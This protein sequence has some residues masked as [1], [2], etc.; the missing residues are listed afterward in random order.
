MLK[1]GSLGHCDRT[2]TK[3]AGGLTGSEFWRLF[4]REIGSMPRTFRIILLSLIATGLT[5]I[6]TVWAQAPTPPP[7]GP[8]GGAPAAGRGPAIPGFNDVLATVTVG[9]QTEKVT[10]GELIEILSRYAIPDDDRETLYRQGIDNKVNTKLLLMYL[11]RQKVAVAPE[12]VDEEMGKL[13]Q[14]LKSEGQSLATVLLQTNTSM[15][16]VRKQIEERARWQ[17]FLR[18]KATDAE[19]R[20]YV[21]NHRDL[22][23]GTQ[24]RASHILLKLEPNAS[25]ADK[26][27]VKEKLASI[28]KE[29]E[30][31][32]I[33]FAAAAN[34]YSD[35]PA[36]A[37]G[38]GG[39]LDYFS[40]NTGLIEEFTDVAFKLKKGMISDPVETPF[41]YHL[42][43]VTDRKEGK[44]PDFEQ[45]KP[46][47]YNAYA[48]DLQK[49]VVAAE[50]KMAKIDIK[51][52]PKD[53]FPPAATTAPGGEALPSTA[54][55]VPAGEAA[56]AE[57]AAGSAAVP[58]Q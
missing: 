18:T 28:K 2:T 36:N 47:I 25:V 26:E 45:N 33:S 23:R 31:G 43:Q 40:L 38:A 58:K 21:A 52:M 54:T 32:T 3:M 1:T 15:D 51:P 5:A 29:I 19:L 55:P 49:E 13:E 11:G 44:E 10:K 57:G 17:E 12:K 14:K 53:L 46:Y 42:I 4:E 7:A 27:K 6:P 30:G 56:K 35:D 24:I 8:G 9:T 22:F 37:G 20:K 41:G 16:V 48:T 50:K 39:D 34:K